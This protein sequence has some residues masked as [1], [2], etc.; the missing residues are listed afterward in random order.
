MDMSAHSAPAAGV[1]QTRWSD[2]ASW[3]DGK[4]PGE[5]DAVTI[6]RDRNILLDVSPPALRSLTLDGRLSF[7]DEADI[8]LKTEWIYVQGGELDIGSEGVPHTRNATITLTDNVPNEDVNTMGDRGIMLLGGTLSLHG[9][10][11]NAWTKLA[12][13]AKA[14]SS[15]IEVLDARGW[16]KGDTIV[17]A[18][19]DF[20]PHQAEQRTIAA[21]GGNTLTLD[22]P[23]QYMHFGEIT[24]G[25]DERGEVGLLTRNIKI[26]ASDDAAKTYF[27]GH[28]MAMAGSKM[29]VSGVELN[30]MGQNMHLARY[31]I[32]WH[33]IGEG[34]GQYIENSSIHDT[35][36]RCVTVHGTNDLR[37]E[38]NVTYNTV[39]HCYFLED[40]VETGNQFVHN[41][42][43]LTKCHPDGSPCVPT[44][45]GPFMTADGKNFRTDGQNARDILI[46]SDNN[47]STFWITNPDNIY[48]DN[49][50]AGSEQIGFWYALPEHPTGAHEGKDLDVF[51]RRTAYREFKGNTAHSNFDGFMSDRGPQ[52]NGHFA[53]GGHIALA[54]PTDAK[55]A[56]VETVIEDF[57][58]YKNRNGG[59]W[60]RGEMDLFKGLKLADNAIGYT[61]ASANFNH[62]LYTSKVVDSL[63]VGES[64]NIG[65]PTTPA[66]VAYG[67][68][69]PEPA[70][71][72]F[73][74]RGYEFYD[75]LHHLDNV[76][77][78]NFQDNATRKTGAI[79][80]LLF[81]SFGMSTN[82]TVQRAHFV[83]AKPVYFPPIEHK[84]SN[85]DYG[86]ATYK[87][88]V[89]KDVDG[90]VGGVPNSFILI[91]DANDAIAIDDACERKPSWNA[92][93][94]KGDV[95]RMTVGGAVV[96]PGFE[97]FGPGG[98]AKA[99]A[100]PPLPVTLTRDGKDFPA[101]GETNVRAGTEFKVTTARQALT[102]NVKELDRGSWVMFELPGFTAADTGTELGSL[103][104]LR[105]ATATAYYKGKDS[106]W[107]KLVSTG[108]TMGSGPASGPGAGITLTANRGDG[109]AKVAVN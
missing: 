22:R 31:P 89:F 103:D 105:N 30:R 28:I 62:S 32:H 6:G 109:E 77:F 34:R 33:I 95:G 82:N 79:S 24:F 108:D 107:V 36:S 5:G 97:N 45:L 98:G 47:V 35:Y 50:A 16:R 63:F 71:A 75:Y 23:L 84:W 57:T 74:I 43:I 96:P 14:G 104:A 44:N 54:D 49:V 25:V 15:R 52:A 102:L 100:G 40:A 38:N 68:S 27:G 85:D 29:Y 46:P 48:R 2:P 19:T 41:L 64:A 20:D 13:T 90:S 51:P 10:R 88:S 4:V 78:V 66:E 7:S 3:P 73:P 55:S 65:N 91:D 99:A 53:V 21:I 8:D 26:Q 106:L 69:L 39:G 72:D 92:A 86:N 83:N 11:T 60:T 42:G 58:S 81:T 76:T 12:G 37:I 80:Y 59:M 67:R 61:H 94:C 9:N 70:L 101:A 17:L 93:V 1:K 56:Q 87:T 18:S